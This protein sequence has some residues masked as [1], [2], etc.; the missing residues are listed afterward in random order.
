MVERQWKQLIV[1]LVLSGAI[2]AGVLILTVNQ[3]TF[4]YLSN[5]S[6]EIILG[7][8]AIHLLSLAFWGLRIQV[9][10]KGLG[11]PLRFLRAYNIVLLGLLP[12]AIT[13]GKVGGEPVRV[14]ELTRSEMK[15]GD[16]TSVIVVERVLDGIFYVILA[17]LTIVFFGSLV[18][19]IATD[20]TYI[21]LLMVAA[22]IA[23]FLVFYYML[24][25]PD[26]L[27]RMLNRVLKWVR[28]VGARFGY[29]ALDDSDDGGETWGEK[30]SRE[31]DNFS[32]SIREFTQKGRREL[33]LGFFFTVFFWISE[34]S[35][36]SLLLV[37]LGQPPYF[38]VSF[39]YQLIIA[40]VESIPTTPG[41]AGVAEITAAS[42]YH[43]ILP[44]S[45]LGVFIVLWRIFLYYINI[46][47]GLLA[48]VITYRKVYLPK[49]EK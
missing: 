26:L 27:K 37:G 23:G 33:Y 8:F 14:Y 42:L 19:S 49:E 45:V 2:L 29:H 47:L 5:L 44:I 43:L 32:R 7:A 30:I 36:A 21:F 38:I 17:G 22:M 6:I 15:A 34:F 1:A 13:P 3:E 48:S 40:I 16:A 12:G 28:K 31:V 25:H 11:Y 35:I 10:A 46:P 9:L 41:S 18:R 4:H 39:L 24:R 20:F